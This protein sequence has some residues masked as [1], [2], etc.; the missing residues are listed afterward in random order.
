MYVIFLAFLFTSKDIFSQPPNQEI[1]SI[2]LREQQGRVEPHL[3][4]PGALL[5]E[6]FLPGGFTRKFLSE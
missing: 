4:M 5:K 3:L 1:P 2:L 6:T